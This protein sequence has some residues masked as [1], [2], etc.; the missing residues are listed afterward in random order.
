[1]PITTIIV[2]LG[3]LAAVVRSKKE[4]LKVVSG[5]YPCLKLNR[6]WTMVLLL[7]FVGMIV[8]FAYT[9]SNPFIYFQF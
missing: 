1:M 9:K 8:I 6:F 2:L 3:T 7:V 4:N 5:F